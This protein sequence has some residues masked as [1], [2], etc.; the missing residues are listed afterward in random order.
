MKLADIERTLANA[1][2]L[3]TPNEGAAVIAAGSERLSPLDQ[4][5][6][7]REQFWWRHIGCLADDYPTL[8]AIVGTEAFAEICTRYLAA[9]PPKGF[10]L[11]DLGRDLS[12]FL[13]TEGD[14]LLVDVSKVEWAFVDAFDAADV[15][16]LDPKTVEGISEDAWPNARL[17]LH[18]S[19]TLVDLEFPADELRIAHR[20]GETITRP[21]PA[22]RAL[23]IYRRDLLLYAEVLDRSA[24]LVLSAI[25]SG[26]TLAEA[27]TYAADA[28]EKI[29]DWFTRWAALGWI[30]SI[31]F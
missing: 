28:E 30:S 7:Y 20:N 29:A 18:P 23:A 8:Q 5:E 14:R 17:S 1:L 15:P 25:A 16:N 3:P 21:Q 4:V 13:E 6:V 31:D 27:C 11:R 24:F 2:V 10:L 9:Y 26:K 19:I 22:P 12:K